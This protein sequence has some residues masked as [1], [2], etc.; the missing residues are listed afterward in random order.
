MEDLKLTKEDISKLKPRKIERRR[1]HLLA[2]SHRKSGGILKG[3]KLV[4]SCNH[5]VFRVHTTETPYS[6]I[7]FVAQCNACTAV[8][9]LNYDFWIMV[10]EP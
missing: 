1:V 3:E 9:L 7:K 4:C 5:D 8:Y 6:D 2:T 10:P